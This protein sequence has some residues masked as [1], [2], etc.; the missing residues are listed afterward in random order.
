MQTAIIT[1]ASNGYEILNGGTTF[2]IG[3]LQH[4]IDKAVYQ[5]N[6]SND[7][8][9]V[10]AN[11]YVNVRGEQFVT[12]SQ[13]KKLYEFRYIAHAPIFS[14]PAHQMIRAVVGSTTDLDCSVDAAPLAT[15]RW[16]NLKG[17]TVTA[18]EKRKVQPIGTFLL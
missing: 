13:F 3:K 8:G 2:K 18:S 10:Y 14:T 11:A 12:K 9:Y 17:A 16:S 6:A 5:C 4:K 15:I 1:L 7:L